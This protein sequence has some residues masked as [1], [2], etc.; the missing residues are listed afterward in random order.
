MAFVLCMTYLLIC[1]FLKNPETYSVFYE[2][3]AGSPLTMT[4]RKTDEE[5]GAA[6]TSPSI[7]FLYDVHDV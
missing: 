7:L 3:E 2:V 1:T 6:L 5:T 4:T